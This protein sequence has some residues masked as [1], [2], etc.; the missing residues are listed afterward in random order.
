MA[1]VNPVLHKNAS[2]INTSKL[3]GPSLTR[4]ERDQYRFIKRALRNPS[5]QLSNQSTNNIEPADLSV[6]DQQ[7]IQR[8][9]VQLCPLC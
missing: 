1:Q 8:C 5:N 3:M 7:F 9:L 2:G 4:L 6:S